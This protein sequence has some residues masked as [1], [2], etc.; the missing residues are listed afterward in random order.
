MVRLVQGYDKG[1]YETKRTDSEGV[2][3]A[4]WPSP[5]ERTAI[6]RRCGRKGSNKME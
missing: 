5:C 3:D 1:I 4:K 2:W 6:L